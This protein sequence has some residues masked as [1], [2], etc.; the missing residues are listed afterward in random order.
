MQKF[1]EIR[2]ISKLV[3]NDII[4]AQPIATYMVRYNGL[5]IATVKYNYFSATCDVVDITDDLT[6][7]E[8][9]N[10]LYLH[11]CDKL[12]KS[13]SNAVKEAIKNSI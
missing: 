3:S 12:K 1:D 7:Y 2:F 4:N 6:L 11:Q 5:Y 8:L 13:I 9:F 10:I